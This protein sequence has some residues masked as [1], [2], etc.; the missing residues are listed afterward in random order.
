MN[1]GTVAFIVLFILADRV[2]AKK[3]PVFYKRME[4]PANIVATL[5][6]ALYG[7]FLV[8][9]A[10][11]VLVSGVSNA[12]KIWFTIFIGICVSVIITLI[13]FLWSR[14]SKERR[15]DAEL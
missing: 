7:G 1:I 10:Y 4:L 5:L 14:W 6:L 15:N 11:E 2:A 12:D 9:A 8:Y 13:I 3:F